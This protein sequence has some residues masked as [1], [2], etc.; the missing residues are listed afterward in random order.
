[1]VRMTTMTIMFLLMVLFLCHNILLPI[2][3]IGSGPTPGSSRVTIIETERLARLKLKGQQFQ[4][5]AERPT[6][7]R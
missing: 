1:M 5:E 4:T 3:I 6:G 7:P 2:Q